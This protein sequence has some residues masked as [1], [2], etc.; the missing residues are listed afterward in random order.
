[1]ADLGETW[2][3]PTPHP[4][5][6][7]PSCKGGIV[8]WVGNATAGASLPPGSPTEALFALNVAST[9]LRVDPTIYAS[10]DNGAT[11]SR[12]L[13]IDTSGGYS[14][15][16]V[17]NANEIVAFYDYAPD[18]SGIPGRASLTSAGGCSFNLA[19]VDPAV[20]LAPPEV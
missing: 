3:N 6:P 16:N 13:K 17:N 14:T 8:R 18:G 2:V 11:F 10:L 20:L 4:E 9:S 19:V 7:D 5:M 1:M 12:S 15:V